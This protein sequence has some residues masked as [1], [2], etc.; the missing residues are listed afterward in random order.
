M[1]SSTYP[2]KGWLATLACKP[3]LGR[4]GKLILLVHLLRVSAAGGKKTQTLLG[5]R[6]RR[7]DR[8]ESADISRFFHFLLHH[9]KDIPLHPNLCAGGARNT[10]PES[11]SVG[12]PDFEGSQQLQVARFNLS[13]ISFEPNQVSAK[14]ISFTL[15]PENPLTMD[16]CSKGPGFQVE[17]FVALFGLD[18]SVESHGREAW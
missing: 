6:N 1:A 17:A 4:L 7:G 14:S 16:R 11:C 18:W 9:Q 15:V 5:L 2:C 13:F 8:T 3:W 12:Q 10:N